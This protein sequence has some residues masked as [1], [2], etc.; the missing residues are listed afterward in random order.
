VAPSR[1]PISA[2]AIAIALALS[3]CCPA[4]ARSWGFATHHYIAQNYSKHLPPYIDGLSAYDGVVDAHVTDPDTR[5]PTTPGEEFRHYIDIDSYPEFMAGAMPHDRAALE[6]QYGAQTVLEIG[7]VP[8]AVGEVVAT[9]T[10]QLQAQQLA[11]A[12]LT[13]ADLCHYV[14]DA[15]QP[16]HC[17]ENYN[18]QLTG[19]TGIHS[20][21]ETT[22][23]SG[24]IGDLSTPL[25]A[26]ADYASPVDAMFGIVSGS[27]DRVDDLLQADNTAKAASGGSYNSVYYASLWNGTQ[28]FTRT[29][30]DSA[31][32]ATAS[33]VYTA[34]IDAGRPAIPGSSTDVDPAPVAV[35]AA[36]LEAGPTPFRD[37]VTIRFAGAGPLSVEVF[38][39]RGARAERLVDGVAGAGT[40]SW[41]PSATAGPGLYFVRLTGPGFSVVRRIARVR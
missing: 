9:L 5:R 27:W 30:I 25:M 38:D 1:T 34:W 3:L 26:V 7:I 15:T 41:R 32:V 40:A 33:F 4:P 18:G 13:I 28:G 8:W 37:A 12:A 39:L 19:N 20:R 24:H 22:M 29:R 10:Q 2:R 31:C 23:M 17:T 14:G 16:L 36:S 6:A 35:G 11:A 21:Y